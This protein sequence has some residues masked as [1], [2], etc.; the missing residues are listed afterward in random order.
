MMEKNG[1]YYR[2]CNAVGNNAAL[3]LPIQVAPVI[4]GNGAG[5][6]D[7]MKGVDPSQLEDLDVLGDDEG[8]MDIY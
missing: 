1:M 3:R 4:R 6:L 7:N 5:R 8:D 2:E